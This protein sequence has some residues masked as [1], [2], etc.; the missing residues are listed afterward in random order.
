MLD[1][2]VSFLITGI[3]FLVLWLFLRKFL[4]GRVRA[5]LDART[6]KVRR[7]VQ[8]AAGARGRAEELKSR[9]EELLGAAEK[10]GE[11]MLL[12][13]EER[14]REERDRVLAE[15]EETAAGIRRRAEEAAAREKARAR[16]ELAAE[17]ARLAVAAARRVAGRDIG[18]ED[19]LREAEEFLRT[20]GLADGRLR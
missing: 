12:D 10:E 20:A 5:F 3:N 16:D 14:A 7:E 9:Y 6:E 11:F 18:A 8:E 19:D 15:A 13:S 2:G 4:F 17:V 1:L